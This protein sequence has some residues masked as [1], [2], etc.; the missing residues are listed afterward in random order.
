MYGLERLQQVVR[1]AVRDGGTATEIAAAVR[2]D[3]EAYAD[4][5]PLRDDFT[6]LVAR[7]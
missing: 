1:K 5:R 3:S 2:A 6:L 4:G 7:F